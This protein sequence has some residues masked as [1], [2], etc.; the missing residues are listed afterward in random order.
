ML[1]LI[2]FNE[3]LI[4]TKKIEKRKINKKSLFHFTTFLVFPFLKS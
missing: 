2:K 1:I 3:F 4:E